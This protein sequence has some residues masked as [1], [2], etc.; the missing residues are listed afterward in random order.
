MKTKMYCLTLA[1]AVV[2]LI[3]V[4]VGVVQAGPCELPVF[5]SENFTNPTDID[6]SYWSLIPGTIFTYKPVPNEEN[7]VNTIEVTSDTKT[8]MGVNCIVVY[9]T[10]HVD[11]ELTE[12]TW[13]WYAQDDDGNIWYFG[14]ATKSL[15][16]Y[17]S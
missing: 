10:E 8:I 3:G 12:E 4:S 13:D 11:S 1:M 17:G 15:Q 16:L 14:E 7:V 9:D 6:N 2:M 5:D